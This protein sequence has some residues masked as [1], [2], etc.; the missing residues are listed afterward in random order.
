MK[1]LKI[2]SSGLIGAVLSAQNVLAADESNSF[3]LGSM[4]KSAASGVDTTFQGPLNWFYANLSHLY[5]AVPILVVLIIVI[6]HSFGAHGHGRDANATVQAEN[7]I[8]KV[9][10]LV[11]TG[12][13]VAGIIYVFGTKFIL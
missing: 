2:I 4:F 11:V 6:V 7:K 10:T 13:I 5:L 9:L 1:S 12:A 3:N 8:T